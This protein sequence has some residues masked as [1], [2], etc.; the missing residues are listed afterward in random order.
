MTKD[1]YQMLSLCMHGHE[2]KR[3]KIPIP[4][5]RLIL[6]PTTRLVT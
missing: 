4:T 2:D 1:L 5:L 3:K 6:G